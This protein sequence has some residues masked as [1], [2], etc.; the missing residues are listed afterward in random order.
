MF[1]FVQ[2]RSR[3]KVSNE[4]DHGQAHE[5]TLLLMASQVE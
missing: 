5:G 1:H 3:Q 4:H 2:L